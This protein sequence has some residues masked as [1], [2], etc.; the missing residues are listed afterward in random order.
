MCFGAD[1]R[2]PD[3][4]GTPIDMSLA[5]NPA[6]LMV[7]NPFGMGPNYDM[8]PGVDPSGQVTRGFDKPRLGNP[9]FDARAHDAMGQSGTGPIADLFRRMGGV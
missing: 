6:Q 8:A 9:R 3:L 5:R 1:E 2:K 7:E 4:P